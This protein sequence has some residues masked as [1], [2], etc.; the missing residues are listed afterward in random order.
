MTETNSPT[1]KAGIARF[2][3]PA[4][5]LISASS[6]AMNTPLAPIAYGAGADATMLVT[7]RAIVGMTIAAVAVLA[8]GGLKLPARAILPSALATFSLFAQS[9]CYL[10]SVAYIPVGL[11]AIIFYTWPLMVALIA[12]FTTGRKLKPLQYAA[13]VL[14]FAGLVIAIGPGFETL[15][16]FGILLAF[17]GAFFLMTFLMFSDNAMKHGAGPMSLSLVANGGVAVLCLG[18]IWF[19]GGAPAIPATTQGWL[20]A[21]GICVFYGMAVVTQLFALRITD[22]ATTAILYNLEPIGS[23]L[24]AAALLGEVMESG[25]YIGGAMVFIALTVFAIPRKFALRRNN[26]ARSAKEGRDAAGM[27][28][29]DT[30]GGAEPTASRPLTEV[31]ERP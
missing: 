17:G 23:V 1:R 31:S 21:L 13:F 28:D 6:F 9:T 26:A 19:K 2:A 15:D 10:A 5:I 25:Q 24:V 8:G 27:K 3:G 18:I 12:P 22:P 14:A 7:F 11:S 29:D 16:P 4:L 30:V 20:A